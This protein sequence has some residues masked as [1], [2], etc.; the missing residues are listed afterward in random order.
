MIIATVGHVDHGKTALLQ[1]LTGINADRLAEE[2]RRGMTIDLGY[3]YW[4]QPDGRIIG[5]ID[6]PGHEKFLSNMLAGVGSIDHALLVVACDDGVMPQTR[7]HLAILRLLTCPAITVA[8]NKADKAS[9]TRVLELRQQV[10][11]LLE[12]SGWHDT[13]MFVTSSTQRQGIGALSQ[14]LQTLNIRRT[15]LHQRFRLAIDRVFNVTGSGL[16][17]TGSAF[18]GQVQ[19][20]DRLWLSGADKMVRVRGLHA[21]N[22][23]VTTASSG[24]R[25]AL[26]IVADVHKSQ[27][28]RGDWLLAQAAETPASQAIVELQALIPLRQW[29]TLHIHHA[30]RH[31]TG[32]ISLL[33]ERFAE[34]RFDAPL[35]LVD[36]DQLILRDISARY[37]L[38]GARVITLHVP[39][40]GKRQPDFLLWLAHYAAEQ[41]DAES[42]ALAAAQHP[43]SV[44]EFSWARQLT[45]Q[46]CDQ[47][48]IGTDYQQ[49]AGY[50]ISHPAWQRWQQQLLSHLAHYHHHYPD[51]S[52]IGRERLRRIALPD[53]PA[54]LA[55]ALIDKL[56]IDGQLKGRGGFICLPEHEAQLNT[57]YQ[58]IWQQLSVLFSDSPWWVRDLAQQ[59]GQDENII[60]QALHYLAKQG[61]VQAIV[62]DRY[63]RYEQMVFFA[64]IVRELH[65]QHGYITTSDF[66]NRIQS[67]RKLA[68]QILEYFD[69]TG[70]TR[71]RG[72]QHWLSDTSLFSQSAKVK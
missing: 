25:I 58:T 47:L 43:V 18:A 14:H 61:L 62:K 2:Q 19:I 48:L 11:D 50:I 28:R 51:E 40:R 9:Q 38:A 71:R 10:N 15:N 12:Q 67:G 31:I 64:D 1:A 45:Q 29:Q 24:Q 21:Q 70:F 65:Q 42:L 30:A 32:R 33:N 69:H 35:W 56:R 13:A 37:T 7:E 44:Q 41:S 46:Q 57:Q 20:A 8:L 54:M 17:V 68:I 6:V 39:R 49:L 52:G 23:P 63:Y 16:V 4:P 59:A 34:L 36:N 60:R 26:N 72:D 27:I 5:F 66:R 3:A 53:L 55:L 22:S